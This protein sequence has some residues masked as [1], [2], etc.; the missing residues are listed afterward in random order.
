MPKKKQKKRPQ[1]LTPRMIYGRD[2][3]YGVATVRVPEGTPPAE[4]ASAIY[5]NK[6]LALANSTRKPYW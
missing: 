3:D 5:R 2:W 4:R 6:Q 1:P